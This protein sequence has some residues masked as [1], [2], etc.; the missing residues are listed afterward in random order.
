M[1]DETTTGSSPRAND[2]LGGTRFDSTGGLEIFDGTNWVP[3]KEAS[4]IDLQESFKIDDTS[5][6]P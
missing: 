4:D 1:S 2:E 5:D 3:L 6:Q